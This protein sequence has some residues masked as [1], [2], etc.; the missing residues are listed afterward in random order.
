MLSKE[1]RSDL[2]ERLPDWLEAQKDLPD[3][4]EFAG[5][6]LER[7]HRLRTELGSENEKTRDLGVRAAAHLSTS[8]ANARYRGDGSMAASMYARADPSRSERP[9][10]RQ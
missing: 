7:A 10:A 3:T 5:Y 6:H 2:H 8:A 4:D 1:S 9:R